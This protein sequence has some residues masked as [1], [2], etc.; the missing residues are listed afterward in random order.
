MTKEDRLSLRE[1]QQIIRDSVYSALPGLYWVIAEIADIKENSSGHVYMELIEK[2]PG[3]GSISARIRGTI[4]G[5]KGRVIN[6]FFKASTGQSLA[7]GMK[8]L[9]KARVDY[10]EVYGIS[11]TITDID[12]AYT[13]GEM[14]AKKTEMI[15]RLEN[16]GVI[17]MNRQLEL[18]GIPNRLAIIS[19]QN[20]A[21]YADF[22]KHLNENLFGFRFK[23]TLFQAAMQ[24]EET[25]TTVCAALNS[26]AN[27]QTSFDA[28]VIIRG[29]GSQA[30]LSWFDNYNIAYLIT[31]FPIPVITGIGHEKDLSV[32]D[33]VAFRSEKTPTA[34]A[35]FFIGKMAES[36]AAVEELA[37][38]LLESTK[39]IIS[40]GEESLTA[41][42]NRLTPTVKMRLN[43]GSENLKYLVS[44]IETGVRHVINSSLKDIDLLK[45]KA[46]ILNPLNIIKRGYTITTVNGKTVSSV[47]S[48]KIGDTI[49]TILP[50]GKISSE[51]IKS[52]KYE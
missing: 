35:D 36:L 9:V 18:P 49:E 7:N 10:H 25:E 11:L 37:L 38:R 30:D 12:P 15:R 31:Q 50:D 23:T 27:F 29:G 39:E 22:I 33:M 48:V 40:A 1:L 44:K 41:L 46:E 16:E 28:V 45:E 19:S 32:T 6:Q 3:E 20:A 26:I 21:G 34:A 4:W 43:S 17:D 5:T 2:Q 8:I 42:G 51:V 13:A 52:E 47:A 24:G 14:A